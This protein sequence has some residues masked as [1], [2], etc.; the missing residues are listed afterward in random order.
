MLETPLT[1]VALHSFAVNLLSSSTQV[2][3]TPDIE[4]TQYLSSSLSLE[5][6][7]VNDIASIALAANVTFINL[8]IISVVR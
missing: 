4:V 6:P 3:A 1:A 8:F 7:R 5:Q 2:I